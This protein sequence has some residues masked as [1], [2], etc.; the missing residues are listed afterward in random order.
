M[1]TQRLPNLASWTSHLSQVPIPVLKSTATALAALAQDEDRVNAQEIAHVVMADPLMAM[2]VLASLAA[3]RRGKTGSEVT[4]IERAIVMMGIGRFFR[5]CRNLPTVEANLADQP[6]ARLGLLR[7]VQ[8]ARRAADFARAFAARRNDV[9]IDE[10]ILAALLHDFA[11]LAIW[12]AA[13]TLAGDMRRMLAATPGLR[14]AAAQRHVLGV[15]V[16]HLQLALAQ[17]WH[18]PQLIRQMMDDE[19]ATAPRVRTVLLAVRLARHL[20][21][22]EA[23]AALPDDYAD[24]GDL[25]KMRS[26]QVPEYIAALA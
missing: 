20:A 13:P 3:Q 14:S 15:E 18:L 23:D 26:E 7:V 22:G 17:R 4:T 9:T 1:L 16:N 19:H 11:E 2:R 24:I 8:R 25:L 10:I 21:S 6:E 12:C 5:E